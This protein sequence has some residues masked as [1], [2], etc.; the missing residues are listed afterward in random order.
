LAAKEL[1]D[2]VGGEAIS[3]DEISEVI[4]RVDLIMSA[5]AAPHLILSAA[6]VQRGLNGRCRQLVILDLAMPADVEPTVADLPQVVLYPLDALGMPG[7]E[8]DVQRIQKLV[9]EGTWAW[10]R[11]REVRQAVPAIVALRHHVDRSEQAELERVLTQLQHLSDDDRRMIQRFGQ[12]LVDKMF[13]HLVARI[14]SLAEYDDISPDVVMTLL[15]RLFA[16]PA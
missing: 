1:A 2:E 11:A 10:A 16:K 15:T 8:G 14:R 3:L 7:R 5:T 6:T 9:E 12:R 4:G 13:H